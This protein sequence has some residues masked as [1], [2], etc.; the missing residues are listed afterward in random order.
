MQSPEYRYCGPDDRLALTAVN[1]EPASSGNVSFNP[2]KGERTVH[3]ADITIFYAAQG[4]GVS[5]YLAAKANWLARRSRI[6]H[7]IV[8]P[9]QHNR[10]SASA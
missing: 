9:A 1:A 6:T 3:L 8:A 7:S 4:G 5:T 2:K 10:A